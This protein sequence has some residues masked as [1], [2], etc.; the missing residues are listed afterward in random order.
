[1]FTACGRSSPNPR[2]VRSNRCAGRYREAWTG[3]S[4]SR[5][6][7]HYFRS[8][9]NSNIL[10]HPAR[11]QEIDREQ[12]EA[13]LAALEVAIN[14][15][16]SLVGLAIPKAVTASTATGI[17]V[18]MPQALASASSSSAQT[19]APSYNSLEVASE[20]TTFAILPPLLATAAE[21]SGDG[22]STP[23]NKSLP[24]PLTGTAGTDQASAAA[25]AVGVDDEEE[26]AAAI[27]AQDEVIAAQAASEEDS[28]ADHSVGLL[29]PDVL[30]DSVAAVVEAAATAAAPTAPAP[31]G[32]SDVARALAALS[33][34]DDEPEAAQTPTPPVLDAESVMYSDKAL[35]PTSGKHTESGPMAAVEEDSEEDSAVARALAALAT[36]AAG[37]LRALET[38]QTP[39]ALPELADVMPSDSDKSLPTSNKH[40]AKVPS[41]IAHRIESPEWL[42][43]RR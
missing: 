33:T 15:G 5:V 17:A 25:Q 12:V 4:L 7:T 10:I 8:H 27:E 26:Q 32:D 29:A 13:R 3:E 6:V 1:M 2:T 43:D 14:A 28:S 31:E 19:D 38:S 41:P 23:N 30:Q 22:F 18:D 40:A 24:I 42:G 21:S 20:N 35:L 16:G 39:G 11:R 9:C 36:T 34:P 37:D